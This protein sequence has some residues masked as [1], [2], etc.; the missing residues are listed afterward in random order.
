MKTYAAA[1]NDA[2]T[3]VPLDGM[4]ERFAVSNNPAEQLRMLEQCA[5]AYRYDLVDR[6][7]EGIT[8][9]NGRD[10]A[11]VSMGDKILASLALNAAGEPVLGKQGGGLDALS[12]EAFDAVAYLAANPKFRERSLW[13]K[14]AER[15]M[16]FDDDT[17]SL[18]EWIATDLTEP[19]FQNSATANERRQRTLRI[20]ASLLEHDA[21]NVNARIRE[22]MTLLMHAAAQG[23]AAWIEFLLE[24]GADP[25]LKD[26]PGR[27]SKARTAAQIAT[28]NG[29]EE[30]A[31][32]MDAFVARQAI[33]RVIDDA[34]QPYKDL[35]S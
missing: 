3:H 7:H 34:R 18:L 17:F 15:Q 26:A 24:R 5:R 4:P 12:K 1:A 33:S 21:I 22:G 2:Q 23:E 35:K 27:G 11:L 10:Q 30:C 13:K 20:L 28:D 32:L 6:I 9:G 16:T 29:Y 8:P 31:Q 14:V 25:L 19:E